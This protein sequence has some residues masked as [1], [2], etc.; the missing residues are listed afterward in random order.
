MAMEFCLLLQPKFY[1][2]GCTYYVP[3]QKT[4]HSAIAA[5]EKPTISFLEQLRFLDFFYSI[6]L[7]VTR[8]MWNVETIHTSVILAVGQMPEKKMKLGLIIGNRSDNVLFVNRRCDVTSKQYSANR[9]L[10]RIEPCFA[11]SMSYRPAS[12]LYAT[13]CRP[14]SIPA[15]R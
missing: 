10:Y 7:K 15:S 1:G 14:T 6:I 12:G 3:L 9:R 13:N 2:A 11:V 4:C 8:E 5:R